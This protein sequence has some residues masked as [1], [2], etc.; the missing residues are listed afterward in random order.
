MQ[1]IQ[2]FVDG[3]AARLAWKKALV[4]ETCTIETLNAACSGLFSHYANIV[5]DPNP[6]RG[7]TIIA[8]P[9]QTKKPSHGC[10]LQL[11]STTCTESRI[12][13]ARRIVGKERNDELNALM[14]EETKYAGVVAET[15]GGRGAEETNGDHDDAPASAAIWKQAGEY[16]YAIVKDGVV[17]KIGGTRT[18]MAERFGSYLCGH[19]V[20]QRNKKNGDPYPGKMSVTNAHLYHTIEHD[21][22][23]NEGK[24]EFWCW[25]LP[26]TT[27]QVEI[28][29]VPTEIIAQ[30]FHA[31]ES[32]C[33]EKF[34]EITGHIP[35]LCDNADPSYR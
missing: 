17:M 27:V 32:R 8:S 29:G 10:R 34:R 28:M 7:T 31:Y 5:L 1:S 11:S 16:I 26:V 2:K 14:G 25:K 19:C 3:Q 18:S 22:L 15:N 33:M 23:E 4:P 24:W 30:T 6:K 35:Q 21:L 12:E 13:E 9:A 20:P